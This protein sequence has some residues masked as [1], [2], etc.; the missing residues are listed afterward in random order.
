MLN[1][2]LFGY[3]ITHVVGNVFYVVLGLIIF[4]IITGLLVAGKEKKINSSINFEG[5]IRKLG[6]V[7]GLAF[8]TFV[9]SYFQTNGNITKIGVGLLVVYEGLSIIE[10]FSRIGINLNFLTQFFD[11]KK[12][13]KDDEK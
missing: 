13:G 12:V 10:N 11:P 7:V 8:V 5:L 3:D 6:L 9:D 2:L 1:N 4:D